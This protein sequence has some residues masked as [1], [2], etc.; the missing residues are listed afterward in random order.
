MPSP[1][2]RNIDIH[3][4]DAI[5]IAGLCTVYHYGIEDNVSCTCYVINSYNSGLLCI[6][7]SDKHP[8]KLPFKWPG[9]LLSYS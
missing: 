8:L 1:D 2:D 3:N 5:V 9:S 7:D 4:Y 6:R